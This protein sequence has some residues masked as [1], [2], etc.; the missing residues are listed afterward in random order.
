MTN[1]REKYKSKKTDTRRNEIQATMKK[2]TEYASRGLE[3]SCQ[4]TCFVYHNHL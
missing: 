2:N 1:T 4:G 3:K